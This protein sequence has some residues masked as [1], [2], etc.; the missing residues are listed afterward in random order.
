MVTNKDNNNAH[1][2]I[3]LQVVFNYI[4][5]LGFNIPI[6]AQDPSDYPPALLLVEG[7]VAGETRKLCKMV[8]HI[9]SA[10]WPTKACVF[11]GPGDTCTGRV[12]L[13][14]FYQDG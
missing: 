7:G 3:I 10:P 4:S 9:P 11:K 1:P 12:L 2:H 5:D 8:I 13:F 6:W 14:H